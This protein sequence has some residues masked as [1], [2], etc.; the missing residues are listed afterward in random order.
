MP[1]IASVALSA[2]MVIGPIVGYIDQ[3]NIQWFDLL[4][5]LL[6]SCIVEVFPHTTQTIKC[7]LQLNDLCNPAVCKVRA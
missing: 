5:A 3:V 1:D 6:N 4:I 2:A 7:W